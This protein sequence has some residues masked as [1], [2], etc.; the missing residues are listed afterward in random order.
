MEFG[1]RRSEALYPS[2]PHNQV[3]FLID[4][5]DSQLLNDVLE[6]ILHH[7]QKKTLLELIVFK[8]FKTSI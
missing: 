5:S 4:F 1:E 8:L 6:V 7:T 3:L 2:F